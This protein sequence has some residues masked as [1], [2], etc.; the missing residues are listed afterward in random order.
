MQKSVAD[1]GIAIASASQLHLIRLDSQLVM[2]GAIINIPPV[3]NT[4]SAKPGSIAWNGSIRI[5]NP[6]AAPSAGKPSEL[7]PR[8]LAANMVLDALKR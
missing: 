1:I 2:Y 7:S 3:A 5:K 6:I 8:Y 4:E